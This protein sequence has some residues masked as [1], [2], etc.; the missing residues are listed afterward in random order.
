MRKPRI[1]GNLPGMEQVSLINVAPC[2]TSSSR[3]SVPSQATPRMAAWHHK[4][5]KGAASETICLQTK[6]SMYLTI[7]WCHPER[8]VFLSGGEIWRCLP[9]VGT[10]WHDKSSQQVTYGNMWTDSCIDFPWLS[11]YVGVLLCRCCVEMQCQELYWINWI[12][13][14]APSPWVR[15]EM[16]LLPPVKCWPTYA[17]TI[18]QPWYWQGAV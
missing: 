4:I 14:E 3:I 12:P 11:H 9:S 6:Y 2:V 10:T 17:T 18:F 5:T 13:A 8:L 7:T 1:P 16:L 15:W